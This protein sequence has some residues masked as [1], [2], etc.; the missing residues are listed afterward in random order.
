MEDQG[1]DAV[2]VCGLAVNEDHPLRQD[3]G[4]K[5]V[6]VKPSYPVEQGEHIIRDIQRIHTGEI[7][8]RVYSLGFPDRFGRPAH[9]NEVKF[10]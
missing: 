9:P 6:F 2:R 5:I 1:R 8:Y 10:V 4:K 3:I 7:V